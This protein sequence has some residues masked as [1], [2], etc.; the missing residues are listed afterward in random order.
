[1]V[2]KISKREREIG[3]MRQ[4]AGRSKKQLFLHDSRDTIYAD[5]FLIQKSIA[6]YVEINYNERR[7]S[8]GGRVH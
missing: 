2:Q 3:K 4:T 8:W 6:E 1:M 5:R 7:T